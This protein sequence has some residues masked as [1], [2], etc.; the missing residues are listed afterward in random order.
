MS[1]HFIVMDNMVTIHDVRKQ[2]LFSNSIHDFLSL[3]LTM[4]ALKK[5]WCLLL[6]VHWHLLKVDLH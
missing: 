6:F 4:D 2:V 1:R 3:S 5:H